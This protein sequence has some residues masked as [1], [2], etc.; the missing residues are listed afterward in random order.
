ML[1][2]GRVIGCTRGRVPG[3]FEVAETDRSRGILVKSSGVPGVV[4][5]C[6]LRRSGV[7]GGFVFTSDLVVAAA[8]T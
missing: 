8:G 2:P 4:S 3:G 5:R 1:L 6:C 7:F